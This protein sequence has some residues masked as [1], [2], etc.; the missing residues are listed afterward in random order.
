MS[1]NNTE[2]ALEV[3]VDTD[4]QIMHEAFSFI[5]KIVQLEAYEFY[6][7]IGPKSVQIELTNECNLRC[8][9][10]NRW[11][12]AQ[13][14]KAR[15]SELSTEDLLDLFE[16]L[17]ELGTAHIL[18]SGGEPL[19]RKDFEVLLNYLNH[20]GISVTL[21]T[22]GTYLPRSTAEL[23][24][25]TNATVIFSVDGSNQNI[26]S[27]IRGRDFFDKVL[28]NIRRMVEVK[29]QSQKSKIVM[30]FVAQKANVSDMISYYNL[31]KALEVDVVSFSIA[32]GPH[33]AEH[34]IGIDKSCIEVFKKNIVELEDYNKNQEKPTILIRDIIRECVTDNIPLSDVMMG[35]PMLTKFKEKPVPCLAASYWA[36]IDA[37][38]DVYP[39]CYVYYDNSS[40]SRYKKERT[41]FCLGNICEQKFIKIWEGEK[42]NRFRKLMNPVNIEEFPMVCGQCGSYFFFKKV[43][44]GIT[45][46]RNKMTVDHSSM[47]EILAQ[48]QEWLDSLETIDRSENI[49]IKQELMKIVTKN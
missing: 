19:L 1:K 48:A 14:T 40:Y 35:M 9:M 3:G 12:W 20:T 44:D 42:F 21:I 28:D 32:H 31:C 24:A 43:I 25:S 17:K 33:V 5:S 30:H 13:E 10:C 27:S 49:N 46:L 47:A 11:K 45:N 29:A 39:C 38:G 34:N 7:I 22:N 8:K 6:K 2:K 16:Q 15:K 26:Y 18:L 36:L 41:K 4:S 37:W 23:L